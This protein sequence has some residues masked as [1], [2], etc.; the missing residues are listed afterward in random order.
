MNA[1][2]CYHH[3]FPKVDRTN[4]GKQEDKPIECMY[5]LLEDLCVKG[6][7]L[8]KKICSAFSIKS[9]A[10]YI[11]TNNF[12]DLTILSMLCISYNWILVGRVQGSC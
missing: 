1:S 5:T 12:I 8:A 6:I 3:K 4:L 11:F 10:F 2:T 9:K 7:G